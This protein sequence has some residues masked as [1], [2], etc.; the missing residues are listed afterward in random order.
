MST[1]LILD[2][3]RK[4]FYT[5][6]W[7]FHGCVCQFRHYE[8]RFMLIHRRDSYVDITSVRM[9]TISGTVACFDLNPVRTGPAKEGGCGV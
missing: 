7:H 3:N 9:W 2:A 4:L 8:L 6:F 5:Y 1:F